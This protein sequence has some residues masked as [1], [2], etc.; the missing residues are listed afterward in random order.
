MPSRLADLIGSDSQ[1][2]Q[3][4]NLLDQ[5]QIRMNVLNGSI[6]FQFISLGVNPRDDSARNLP[7]PPNR[8][9]LLGLR[10]FKWLVDLLTRSFF[11]A[12]RF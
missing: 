6:G 7:P 4:T 8:K 10:H 3:N 9:I 11:S 12:P 2:R 1:S 5:L